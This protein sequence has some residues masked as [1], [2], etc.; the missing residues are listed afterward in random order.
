[1]IGLGKNLI[2][3]IRRNEIVEL[4]GTFIKIKIIILISYMME[5][6]KIILCMAID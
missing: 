4:G 1:M 6:G 5:S 2:K 3:E